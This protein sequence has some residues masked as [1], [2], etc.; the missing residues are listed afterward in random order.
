MCPDGRGTRRVLTGW[1]RTA[2]TGADV[3][4]P[5]GADEV[6]AHL[7]GAATARGT[8]ARGL[9]RS[10]GDA[11]QNAGGTVMD[12][13]SL[14]GIHHADLDRGRIEVD[15]GVSLGDI[16][17]WTTPRGWFPTVTPGT[18]FVTVGGAVAADI[19]GKNHHIDGTFTAS[20]DAMTLHTPQGHLDLTPDDELFRA[21]AGGMGLTGVVT[22]AT[23]GLTPVD[24]AYMRVD[25]ERA[26][27]LDDLM[28][29]MSDRDHDYR[30]S[31]AWIDCLATGKQLGRG[32]LTR[33]DHATVQD[34][35]AT[36]AADP[37]NYEPT[38]PLAAPPWAPD[39]LLNR[40]TVRAF[41]EL[42]F[43]KAPQRRTGEI[44]SIP[45]FFHPL[46]AVKGWNRMYG[47]SGFLQYQFVVPLGHESALRGIIERL[48]DAQVASFLAV[49]KRFGPS[50][51][52]PLSFPIEGWT[53]ALDLP[54]HRQSHVL[55]GLLASFDRVVAEA[56]G[57][58]YL[59]KDAR[60]NPDLLPVMYPDLDRWREIRDRVD[61]D[62]TLTSDLDRRLDLTGRNT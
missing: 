47:S 40:L 43:R 31:V 59:A 42:W 27:D 26:G 60:L 24:T 2:P 22:R 10:Y 7:E 34:L 11:A 21:T 8:V 51:Q 55:T 39:G 23:V 37:L 44:Q 49:L 36:L 41:N 58:V 16:M 1:G 52:A 14:R 20:V 38:Q 33:G 30:Y 35:S 45:A 54:V 56:G 53:L 18:R 32:V 62:H 12:M 57:R 48:T 29:R 5:L 25:T 61:P 9:G 28:A 50:N 15:A 19:H 3:V 13:T 6:A 46:D 17:R 4:A